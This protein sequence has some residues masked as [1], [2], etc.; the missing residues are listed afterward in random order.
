MEQPLRQRIKAKREACCKY[1]DT[2]FSPAAMNEPC[3]K[4]KDGRHY[5]EL[6]A[7]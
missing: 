5:F 2:P 4:A 7:S 1:C 3:L 6:M